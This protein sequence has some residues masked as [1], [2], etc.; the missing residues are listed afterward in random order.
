MSYNQ[1]VAYICLGLLIIT[2]LTKITTIG[3]QEKNEYFGQYEMKL[4]LYYFRWSEWSTERKI[5]F[6]D[7]NG[8]K[9]KGH[10]YRIHQTDKK[11]KTAAGKG[12]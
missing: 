5:E 9:G 7:L 4:Y 8:T 6:N 11:I 3:R 12:K 1:N 2:C 10:R